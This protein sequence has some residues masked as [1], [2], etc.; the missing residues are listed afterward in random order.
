MEIIKIYA[1]CMVLFMVN[2]TIWM[3]WV[4][5]KIRELDRIV[6]DINE[7]N[8]E[9]EDIDREIDDIDREIDELYSDTLVDDKETSNNQ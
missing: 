5:H 9:L 2:A 8:K 1:I 6:A 7:L 4:N 3:C